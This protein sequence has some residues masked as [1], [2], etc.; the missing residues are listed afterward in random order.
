MPR[1]VRR[2][3]SAAGLR[4]ARQVV[5]AA[6]REGEAVARQG[7]PAGVGH[8][9]HL[10]RRLGAVEEGVEHLRVEVAASDL[11]LAE[12]VMA[13]DRVGRGGVVGR[14]VLGALP[15]ADHLQP[16]GAGPVDQL[17]DERRLVARG[18]RVDHPGLGR[19]ARQQR[20]GQ[21]VGLDV[22]HDDVLGRREGLERV[23]DA[24]GRATGGVDDDVHER[25]RDHRVGIL[26][27]EGRAAARGR[28]QRA[29]G[30]PGVV[31]ADPAQRFARP[32]RRQVGHRD[33]VDAGRARR[34]RQVHRAELAGAD[35]A[36]PDRP[37]LV[38]AP[39][40][41]REEGH[42]AFSPWA[43]RSGPG[44]AAFAALL[45]RDLVRFPRALRAAA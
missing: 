10:Q 41:L 5:D 22:D 36:D 17:G 33:E 16:D 3:P 20:P 2:P 21:H 14:E 32:V 19:P 12:A 31:P 45:D 43:G 4:D 38:G 30:E 15:G 39:P 42:G 1:S 40:Q 23:A 8:G 25:A 37:A 26:G 6:G 28:L 24:G 27:H 35:Q 29:R 13:P 9:G 44:P 34:L 18:H 11:A 7:E